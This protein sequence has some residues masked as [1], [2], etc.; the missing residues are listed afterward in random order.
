M[1]WRRFFQSNLEEN[2]APHT[3]ARTQMSYEPL[4][5]LKPG[6]EEKNFPTCSNLKANEVSIE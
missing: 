5:L 4:G 3:H 2:F 6:L 1:G